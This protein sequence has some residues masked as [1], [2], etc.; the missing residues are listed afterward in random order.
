MVCVVEM[1]APL[2]R[3]LRAAGVPRDSDPVDAWRRLRTVEGPGATIIDLYELA[4]RRRGLS[5]HDLPAAERHALALSVM[6][7]VWPGWDVTS[8]SERVGDVIEIVDYDPTWPDRFA[9]WQQTLRAALGPEA[10]RIEHIGSTSVPGLAAKPVIDIQV[11]VEDLA[12]EEAYVPALEAIGLQLRSR[13]VFHRFFRPFP[14]RP[15]NVHVHVCEPGSEWETR[16]LRFRDHLRTHP[17][18]RDRYARAKRDAAALWADDGPAYTDAKT[19]VILDILQ[20][21]AQD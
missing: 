10:D 12:H 21:A 19:E 13:D 20:H 17:D 1:R 6:P 8:G 15:R 7:D 11:G 3:R 9:A 2:D 16:H 4:A 14:G 5:A 18:A